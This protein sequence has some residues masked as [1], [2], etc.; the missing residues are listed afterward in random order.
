[1]YVFSFEGLHLDTFVVPLL[2]NKSYHHMTE[3]L[4]YV[5]E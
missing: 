1:M 4:M 5:Y 3:L 2:E